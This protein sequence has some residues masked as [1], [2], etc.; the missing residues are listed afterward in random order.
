[1]RIEKIFVSVASKS[2]GRLLC[3]LCVLCFGIMASASA[4]EAPS[5]EELLDSIEKAYQMS[6]SRIHSAVGTAQVRT[7]SESK[8]AGAEELKTESVEEKA[9]FWFKGEKW[10]TDHYRG[11]AI[12]GDTLVRKHINTGETKYGYWPGSNAYIDEGGRSDRGNWRNLGVDFSPSTF[13]YPDQIAL[14]TQLKILFRDAESV[15]WKLDDEGL[16]RIQTEDRVRQNREMPAKS[17]VV[18]DPDRSYALISYHRRSQ[19]DEF[20][21]TREVTYEVRYDKGSDYPHRIVSEVIEEMKGQALEHFKGAFYVHNKHEV[22]I[23]DINLNST[24][25]DS[26]FTLEGLDIQAGTLVVNSLID[27]SYRSGVI[28]DIDEE[29]SLEELLEKVKT[30]DLTA[31]EPLPNSGAADTD[32]S[33]KPGMAE[34]TTET[35]A[36]WS[37]AVIVLWSVLAVCS[38]LAVVLLLK[39]RS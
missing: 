11:E 16:L 3:W 36:H 31:V 7:V 21:S 34:E 33:T 30:E 35:P 9:K 39:K 37:V 19:I 27:T 26:T 25:D 20:G 8:V 10:R 28:I 13:A 6:V 22:E 17:E 23:T 18:L 24:I 32:S 15:E 12:S 38:I 14:P 5:R 4:E 2:V 1:M 29:K